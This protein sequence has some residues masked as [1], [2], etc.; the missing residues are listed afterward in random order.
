MCYFLGVDVGG[1]KTHALIANDRG[2]A[3]GFSE[4]GSGNHQS[5]G[6]DG[7]RD[8][9]QLTV[10]RVL[11]QAGIRMDQ[12][13]GAGF[14]I[15]GYDWP[16][17]TQ[18]HLEAIAPLGLQ[19]PVELA[20]DSIIGLMAGAMRGWGVVLIAGTG[21]N[22][23]GRDKYGREARITGEGGRFGEFGGAAEMVERAVQAVSHEWT[24]RGPKTALTQMFIEMTGA[25]DLDA[26]IEGIDLDCYRPDASWAP[27]V[28]EAAHNGDR[29]ARQVIA[30]SGRESGESACAVI[31][32]LNIMDEEF[33]VI[34][35]G[36]VFD[37]GELYIRP[38]QQTIHKLAPRA[39]LVKLEAPPVVGGVVLGMQKAG[40]QTA[41]IHRKLILS[42][43]KLI[44]DS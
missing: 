22:C 21:N 37:G 32:Q 29:V 11:R 31:R 20:N 4:G 39:K 33:E 19:C 35:A 28:F 10:G 30:W 8:V 41:P 5:V 40:L 43:K 27:A 44:G 12:I 25:K 9:I 2:H 3:L 7:L 38:L 18:V 34:L 42:T 1:T 16:S 26:L 23:R 6:Y 14:G 24:H 17:Q 13:A 15:G 36:R